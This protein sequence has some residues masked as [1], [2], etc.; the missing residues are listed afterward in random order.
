MDLAAVLGQVLPV[1]VEDDGAL[2][3]LHDGTLASF[4]EVEI[5]EG[6]P[7]VSLNQLVAWDVQLTDD[8]RKKVAA[9]GNK[10]MLGAIVLT[11]R[12][13]EFADVMLRYNFPAGG[14]DDQALQTLVLM[15]LDSGT[16]VRRA[17]V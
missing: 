14:L 2:T 7:M 9:Q 5:S 16:Q 17:L 12:S 11:E 8:L 6:L 3:V 1:E 15:V 10:T 13:D 4:R